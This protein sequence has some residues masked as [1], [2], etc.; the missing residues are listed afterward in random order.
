[1]IVGADLEF[2]RIPV[3]IALIKNLDDEGIIHVLKR[4]PLSPLQ[5][6]AA[7]ADILD[8]KEHTAEENPQTTDP[9]SC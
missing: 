8:E 5:N 1:M 2:D 3:T 4:P 6:H 7:G 9:P